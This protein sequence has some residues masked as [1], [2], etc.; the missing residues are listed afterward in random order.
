MHFVWC[1]LL[2]A[3][4]LVLNYA[5]FSSIIMK[6]MS[7]RARK[8]KR[9]RA[10]EREGGTNELADKERELERAIYLV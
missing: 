1:I 5:C 2:A 7:T 6:K 3:C 8:R 9:K 10:R 4:I